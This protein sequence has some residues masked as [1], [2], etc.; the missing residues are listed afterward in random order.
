MLSFETFIDAIKKV[1]HSELQAHFTSVLIHAVKTGDTLAE[2][3]FFYG[4]PLKLFF[5]IK[6]NDIDKL[7]QEFAVKYCSFLVSQNTVF[8]FD[9]VSQLFNLIKRHTINHHI[10]N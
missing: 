7:V 4:S 6:M 10:D 8:D 9:K 2:L 1:K 3:V 5:P